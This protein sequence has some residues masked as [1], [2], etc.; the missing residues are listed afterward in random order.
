MQGPLLAAMPQQPHGR[1]RAAGKSVLRLMAVRHIRWV[2]CLQQQQVLVHIVQAWLRG[3]CFES[4]NAPDQ[5]LAFAVDMHDC[6]PGTNARGH[7]QVLP[8]S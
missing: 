3:D 7:Q 5:G 4:Q 1:I 8:P 6:A 2:N